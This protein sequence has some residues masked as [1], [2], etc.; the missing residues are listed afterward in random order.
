M[1]YVGVKCGVTLSDT[2]LI[3]NRQVTAADNA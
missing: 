2:G 3:E 1:V